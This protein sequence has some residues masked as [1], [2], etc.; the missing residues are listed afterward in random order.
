MEK[1][2]S[3]AVEIIYI[4][5]PMYSGSTLLAFLLNVHPDVVTIGERSYFCRLVL[6]PRPGRNGLN[7]CSCGQPVHQCEFLNDLR[8]KVTS[9]PLFDEVR[10][11]DF[12][13]MEFYKRRTVN[14]VVRAVCWRLAERGKVGIV[15]KALKRFRNVVGINAEIARHATELRKARTFVDTSK[16]V[17][18]AL[19]LDWYT[20]GKLLY[21]WLVRDGRSYVASAKKHKGA[22]VERASKLWVSTIRQQER[23]LSRISRERVVRIRYEDLCDR[24]IEALCS[25]FSAAGLSIPDDLEKRLSAFREYEAH[26]MGNTGTCRSRESDVRK[27]IEW[28]ESLTKEE[29]AVFHRTAGDTNR[30]LG[31]I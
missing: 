1:P 5:G 24:T 4:V 17:I 13:Q 2:M 16:S 20:R 23:F 8:F 14:R 10:H 27:R 9:S 3:D 21:V 25:I 22:D 19:Y 31:Y 12:C 15:G 11:L 6:W 30:D 28:P 7:L 29:L 26:I 18:H